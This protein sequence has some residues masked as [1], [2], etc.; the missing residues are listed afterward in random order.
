MIRNFS[1]FQIC[2]LTKYLNDDPLDRTLY[3]KSAAPAW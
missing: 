3:W 1:L 2:R